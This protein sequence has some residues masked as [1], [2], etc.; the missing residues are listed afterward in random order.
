MKI[1]DEWGFNEEIPFNFYNKRKKSHAHLNIISRE[2]TKENCKRRT[3]NAI[4]QQWLRATHE[5]YLEFFKSKINF[6]KS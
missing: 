1:S 5:N 4:T 3:K 2:K 6:I